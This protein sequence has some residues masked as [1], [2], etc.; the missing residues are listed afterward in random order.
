MTINTL[1]YHQ[2]CFSYFRGRNL[3]NRKNSEDC[4]QLIQQCK[5]AKADARNHLLEHPG[6]PFSG[7]SSSVNSKKQELKVHK[8]FCSLRARLMQTKMETVFIARSF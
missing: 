8:Q 7:V 1:E 3:Q 6:F 2:F 4:I 5:T